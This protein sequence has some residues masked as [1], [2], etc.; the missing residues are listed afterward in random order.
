MWTPVCRTEIQS[1]PGNYGMSLGAIGFGNPI[2]ESARMPTTM[3]IEG[4]SQSQGLL[5]Q[6]Q[7]QLLITSN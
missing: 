2:S 6:F 3:W 1:V 7:E 4:A 5:R